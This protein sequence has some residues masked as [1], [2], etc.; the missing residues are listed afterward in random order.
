VNPLS[1]IPGAPPTG[2]LGFNATELVA[3]TRLPGWAITLAGLA[4]A[5]AL[6]WSW[7]ATRGAPRR[8]R[9]LFLGFRTLLAVSLL[10]LLLEP[11][12][13]YMA[14]SREANRVVL[15]VDLSASMA[16][17]AGGKQSRARVALE[18]AEKVRDQLR[19]E[20]GTWAP[21]IWAFDGE[22]RPLDEE[23]VANL[24]SGAAEAE[25]D[26]TNLAAI[27]D[28]L[29]SADDRPLGGV[30]LISDGDD[31]ERAAL[32]EEVRGRLAALGAPVHTA[33]VG[34]ADAFKDIAIDEVVADDFAFVRNPVEIKVVLRERGFAG[35]KVSLSLREDGRPIAVREVTLE[36]GRTEVSLTFEPK[37]SGKRVYT[38]A[39]PPQAGEAITGNN[40][41]DVALKIIRDRIRV[42]QLVGRPSWDERFVRRLLK[43]NPSVDLISF[44]ILRSPTDV[45]GAPSSELSLIPFPTRELFTEQLHTFDVVI[46]QDF[47]YR[48][49]QMAPY[50]KNVKQFVEDAGG[51]FMMIG[52]ELSF[53]EGDYD[54]TPIADVLPVELLP[55]HGHIQ[56]EKFR[57]LL[58]DAGRSHPITDLGDLADRRS[59]AEDRAFAQLP[60]LAGVNLVRGLKP[61]AEA[62]LTHPFL[63]AGGQP[64]PVVA[65]REVGRGRSV[66]VM[67]DTAWHWALPH[68]G[69]GGRGDAHRRFFANALRWLIR[70]PELSRVKVTTDKSEY[71]PGEPVIATVR[72]F[73]AKYA[74]EGGANVKLTLAPLDGGAAESREG[75]TD[76]TGALELSFTG[77]APGAWRVRVDAMS[78]G[79]AIG[80]DENAFVV[81]RARAEA[82]HVEP[83]AE[84][85]EAMAGSGGGRF[86]HVEDAGEV[87]F[88][89]HGSVRVHRQR[90]EPLWSALWPL[91]VVAALAATEWWWRRRRGLA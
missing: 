38:V 41:A 72:S 70:D 23:A 3:L 87:S 50:L 44:F 64:A 21:E 76:K 55:G 59:V 60:E 22:A 83:R 32:G 16:E 56:T 46:F 26:R 29:A 67:T 65:V 20:G 8:L 24:R 86:V 66:A 47:N 7:R 15:A 40:R 81:R 45:A 42:L 37:T 14:T 62:L 5:V 58:T 57:P 35:A 52:G 6:Y 77:L 19:D 4:L 39:I 88:K 73:D 90:T 12:V 9:I 54:G 84:L 13:R 85:L 51:G 74:A 80:A 69:A 48:P 18:A 30:L 10:V 1:W 53:S 2:E 31:T 36:E 89:D 43:E 28:V 34:R 17:D 49:Y 61:D 25:G 68:V 75:V 79:R 82:L 63:N 78:A 91:L 27:L 33:L 11:G 71:D